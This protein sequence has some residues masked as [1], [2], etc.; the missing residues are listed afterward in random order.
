MLST[1]SKKILYI[2]E[3]KDYRKVSAPPVDHIANEV[4]K[5]FRDT[6]F[7]I[8]SGSI[9]EEDTENRNFLYLAR[10][11]PYNLQFIFHFESPTVPYNS[12]LY[13]ASISG[14]KKVVSLLQM[15]EKLD[16]LLGPMKNYLMV[17]DISSKTEKDYPWTVSKR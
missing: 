4:A 15:Q 11:K 14:E 9:C 3:S 2:I 13:R 7:G 10:T 5:K 1:T 12:G 6:L 8:W 17:F 16:R